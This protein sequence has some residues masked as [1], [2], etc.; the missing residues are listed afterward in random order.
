MKIVLTGGHHSSA[1]P[2]IKELRNRYENL[3]IFWFGHKHSIKGNKNETL[4]FKEIKALNIPF[5]D[6]KAGKFYRTFDLARLAKIPFGFFQS[7]F[8]LIKIRPEIILSFGGY[9][10]VPTVLA[11]WVLGIPSITHEQTVVAG[12][13]N[14]LISKFVKKIMYSWESSANNFSPEK[15]IFVGLPLRDEIFEVKS[16]NF[17]VNTVLPTIYITAGKTGSHKINKVVEESLEGLLNFYNVIHQCGDLS[18]D[19]DYERLSCVK[20]GRGKYYPRKFVFV[21]EI[22]E[23]FNKADL[24]ISRAGAHIIYEMLCL[25]K[26]ALL[27]PISWSSHNEQ[28]KN[29]ENMKNIGLAEILEE[30]DLSAENLVL[31]VKK[32]LDNMEKYKVQNINYK[33]DSAKLIVDCVDETKASK[34]T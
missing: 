30:K 12:Y 33:K 3:E 15:A 23:V 1:L 9:L 17:S 28:F 6:L 20:N 8:W 24:I 25:Q 27:I 4:E 29:A 14:R 18:F 16:D 13:A 32:M 34:T 10:A 5:Y 21:N 2:V 26:P 22:G 11:G 31:S 19:N 7:L